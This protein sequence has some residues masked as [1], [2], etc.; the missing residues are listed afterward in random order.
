MDSHYQ[1]TTAVSRAIFIMGINILIL[2]PISIGKDPWL[3]G[4]RTVFIVN[5]DFK[6]VFLYLTNIMPDDNL[7]KT[8]ARAWMILCFRIAGHYTG[9]L[10]VIIG[11]PT[12]KVCNVDFCWL[13]V[14]CCEFRLFSQISRIMRHLGAH[15]LRFHAP[16]TTDTTREKNALFQ[17]IY[18]LHPVCCIY[19]NLW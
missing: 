2:L 18:I 17:C 1:D 13:L 3:H 12:Q 8:R 7:P 15:K 10:P 14:L 16:F 11:F 9:N 6:T 5:Q 4:I 19:V